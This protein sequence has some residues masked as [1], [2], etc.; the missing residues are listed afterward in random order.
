VIILFI[1]GEEYKFADGGD[2]VQIWKEAANILNKQSQA[3]DKEWFF[4]MG[5]RRG[6][7]NSSP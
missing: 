4:S 6:A 7:K 1:L 5:V 3:A 2:V